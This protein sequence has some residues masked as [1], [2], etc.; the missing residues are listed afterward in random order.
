MAFPDLHFT[1]DRDPDG[2]PV[3]R[4]LSAELNDQV[5]GFLFHTEEKEGD[6]GLEILDFGFF[7]HRGTEGTENFNNFLRA[8]SFIFIIN[9]IIRRDYCIIIALND[10]DY[11]GEMME[12]T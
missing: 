8:S 5:D 10:A 12:M 7:S 6:R 3:N 2:L 9:L 1:A 4:D 11:D